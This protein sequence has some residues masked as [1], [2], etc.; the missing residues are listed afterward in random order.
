[1]KPGGLG[2]RIAADL[3]HLTGR[4][5]KR[6]RATVIKGVAV[7]HEHAEAV[8]AARQIEHDEVAA[9]RALRPREI[10]QERRNSEADRERRH[11]VLEELTSSNRHSNPQPFALSPLLS[12]LCPL[13]LYTN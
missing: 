7:R 6:R 5:P 1:M 12:A 4:N 11:A 8:V 3:E 2:A 10:R 13:R 9:R